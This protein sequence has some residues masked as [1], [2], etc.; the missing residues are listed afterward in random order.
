MAA[1]EG[2]RKPALNAAIQS[3]FAAVARA[4][5]GR[6]SD[7]VRF[8]VAGAAGALVAHDLI[9]AEDFGTLTWAWCQTADPVWEDA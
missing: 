8:F 6:S 1:H 7:E 3:V 2:G 9:T 5:L 4:R